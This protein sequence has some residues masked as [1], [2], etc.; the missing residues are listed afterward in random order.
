MTCAEHSLNRFLAYAKW[1]YIRNALQEVYKDR[2]VQPGTNAIYFKV[3]EIM[4]KVVDTYQKDGTW[5]YV[6]DRPPKN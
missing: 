1:Q 4:N 5:V 2:L 6:Y 3:S